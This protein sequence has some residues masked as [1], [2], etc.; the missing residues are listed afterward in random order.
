LPRTRS[1]PTDKGIREYA[2]IIHELVV[3]KLSIEEIDPVG[4]LMGGWIA[5]QLAASFPDLLK[6]LVLE[7]SAGVGSDLPEKIS[8]PTLILW[9][10]RDDI[11]PLKHAV[12]LSMNIKGS[13]S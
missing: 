5:M 12:A 3:E 1:E 13:N 2:K 7:D 4:N 11:L 6:H 9:G 8:V 10:E